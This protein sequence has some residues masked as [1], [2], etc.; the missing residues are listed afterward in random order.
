[1]WG[2][3]LCWWANIIYPEHIKEQITELLF[4][5]TG[6]ELDIVR[7]NLGGGSNHEIKQNFRLGAEMPCIKNKDG[8]FDLLN[9]KLQ[10][11]M[12]DASIAKGVK[13]VEIFSNS[14]PWWMTKS[15]V[16]NG[17]YLDCNLKDD[18]IEDFTSFLSDSYNLLRSKY[19]IVSIDPFN[20]PS[21]PFWSPNVNQEGS[22]FG[23]YK[24]W[25]IIKSLKNKNKDIFLSGVDEFS[26][27]FALFWYIFSPRNLIDRINL[28]GY[29]LS[30]KDYIFY[31]DDFNIW[32][33]ILRW[34]TKKPIW[35]SEYGMG[36]NDT[37]P[38]SLPLGRKI[39]NDL[40]LLSPEG[41]IY[42]QAVEDMNG[43]NW[44]LLQINFSDPTEI[45]IQKQYYIFKHFTKNIKRG[46][47]LQF[48]NNNIIKIIG[49]NRIVYLILNDTKDNVDPI[50]I[51]EKIA[52]INHSDKD[53][54]YITIEVNDHNN[55]TFV[56]K[57]IP[58]SIT[59][60][61]CE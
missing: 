24:R 44:G 21:N 6:L 5:S 28:H 45:K 35:M 1:M 27:G 14:P 59:T 47:E 17:K 40:K 32:K 15:G 9:D 19:P 37:I 49:K 13:E 34:L 7:Y 50:E 57:F 36:Y 10:L 25:K 12:L 29:R 11:S 41:W 30:Y 38:D 22:F 8:T 2:T 52:Y 42:W 26:I 33:R 23:Y 4:G 16:T 60:I 58:Y 54:D 48:I 61:V 53:N 31:F 3:S 51:K 56:D 55:L 20:E 43:S 18:N 39:F 46:D